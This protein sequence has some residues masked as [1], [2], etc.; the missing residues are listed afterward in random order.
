M[1]RPRTVDGTT[2]MRRKSSNGNGGDCVEVAELSDGGR[3]VCDSKDRTGPMPRF[4]PAEWV[5]FAEPHRWPTSPYSTRS[6]RKASTSWGQRYVRLRYAD[7]SEDLIDPSR[8]RK[9]SGMVAGGSRG[10]TRDSNFCCGGD[11]PS[12]CRLDE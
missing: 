10:T 7:A 11:S 3:A 9:R 4:T 8:G 5:A 1:I 6:P 12:R 2:L